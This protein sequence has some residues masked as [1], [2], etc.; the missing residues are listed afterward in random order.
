MFVLFKA[1][2][3]LVPPNN[4]QSQPHIN[5]LNVDE[6][7][8]C[9]APDAVITCRGEAACLGHVPTCQPFHEKFLTLRQLRPVS[10]IPFPQRVCGL[11]FSRDICSF[12]IL[13]RGHCSSVLSP[14]CHCSGLLFP[15]TPW[16]ELHSHPC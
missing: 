9:S 4:K 5:E 3:S 6:Q 16:Q 1:S 13:F 14:L 12:P 8:R 2:F 10:P 11:G 7:H 15:T